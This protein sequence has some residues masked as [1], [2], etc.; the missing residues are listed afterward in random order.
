MF[1]V[2]VSGSVSMKDNGGDGSKD[3]VYVS[4]VVTLLFVC[5]GERCVRVT[6]SVSGV[7]VR[8]LSGLNVSAKAKSIFKQGSMFNS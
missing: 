3:D 7:S 5:E 2:V 8:K 6:Y 4:V 1:V